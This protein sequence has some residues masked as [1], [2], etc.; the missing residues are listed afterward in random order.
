MTHPITRRDL[1]KA[2][3]GA[4]A[5]GGALAGKATDGF[6]VLFLMSDEHSPHAAGWLGN[7]IVRTPALDALA[8]QG[9]AFT[10]AYCQNPIC[11]P[12]RASFLTSR[13]PS[14]VGVLANDGG[15]VNNV[16]T[17]A[18]EFRKAG[19]VTN[20]MGKTHW[21]G[22]SGFDSPHGSDDDTS[23]RKKGSRLPEDAAVATWPITGEIDT[24]AKNYALRF[25][26]ENRGK[27][28]F[29][30]VSFRKPH[31]PFVVQE[32]YYR[33]YKGRVDAPRV[34]PK[35]IDELPLLSRH[36][37][38]N[39][40]F[41]K[42]TG[43][44]IRKAREIYYGMVT[45]MDGLV[46]E[47]LKK[48]DELGLRENTII[49]YTADHGEM[50]GEHGLW[51]KNSFYEGSVHVPFVWSFPKAIRQGARIDAPVMNMDIFPTLCDLCG[52]PKPQS[53]EGRSL[54]PL[55]KGTEDGKDRYAMAENFRAGFA[56]RMIRQG[57]WK[58]CYFHKDREQLF[59]LRNDP[60]E[61]ENLV[62]RPEHRE[63]IA[64]LKARILKNWRVEEFLNRKK[65]RNKKK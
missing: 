21:G 23:K 44:Q 55:M 4:P 49:L 24:A 57:Q 14:E 8:R 64:A 15:L 38:E 41:A 5:A 46:G 27:R 7:K 53:L 6:N 32:E 54:L 36:E 10:S 63:M 2:I 25:L 11:V 26:E 45:Y 62:N 39:Y 48:V 16:P 13:M 42:L 29:A 28:F 22:E 59:D 31:F 12:S 51:Y 61:S 35:M 47:V 30:G 1:I 3:A 34:T 65:G 19:Y 50:A 60:E 9:T 52:V 33:T 40:G 20:W 58:Y 17:L 56:G 37:R 43:P 18:T